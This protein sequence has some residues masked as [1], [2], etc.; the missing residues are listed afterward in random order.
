M[1]DRETGEHVAWFF[2]TSLD[3]VF[4]NVPHHLW[5]LPWHRARIRFDTRFDAANGRYSA[6]RM[7]TESEWAPAELVLRDTGEPVRDYA[8]FEDAEEGFRLLTHPT[9]GVSYRRD[10]RLGTYSIWHDR[11]QLT[12]GEAEVAR[13]PLLDSLGLV[14]DGALDRI[15]SVMIQPA[16]EFTIYLPPRPL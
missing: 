3:T 1:T 8:G 13:F 10:G 15:H 16:V 7:R 14:E 6:Y 5:K 12:V 9:I 4:V 2:G 11:M